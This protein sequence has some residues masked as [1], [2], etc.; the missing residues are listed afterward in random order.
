MKKEIET[1]LD[2][3]VEIHKVLDNQEEIQEDILKNIKIIRWII[4]IFVLLVIGI[5]IAFGFSGG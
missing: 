4:V 5:F 2:N 3:Q 1:I